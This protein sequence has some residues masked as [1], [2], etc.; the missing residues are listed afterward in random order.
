LQAIDQR[1]YPTLELTTVN[2]GSLLLMEQQINNSVVT[3]DD[4]TLAAADD[5][6]QSIRKN[7]KQLTS[8]NRDLAAQV[9]NIENQLQTWYENASR[10]A[11]GFIAGTVDFTQVAA[12][13]SANAERLKELR[14][15]LGNMKRQT[16]NTFT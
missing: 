6:Y 5:Y 9:N 7:L 8:L 3:G 11:G 14:Q 10:I 13:A 4:Q 1:L 2:L 12:E 15:S 16:Q